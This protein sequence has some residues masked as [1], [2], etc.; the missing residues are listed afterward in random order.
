MLEYSAIFILLCMILVIIRGV[1]GPTVYDRIMASNVFGSLT[2]MFI[3]LL[4]YSTK[5]NEYIDIAMIYGVINFIST[6]ALLKYFKYRSFGD[7]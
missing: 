6:I 4:S 5:N 7:K 2:V 1:I 3:A